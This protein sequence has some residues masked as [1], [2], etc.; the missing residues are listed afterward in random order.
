[1]GGLK[2]TVNVSLCGGIPRSELLSCSNQG[3]RPPSMSCSAQQPQTI[4][5]TT[6]QVIRAAASTLRQRNVTKLVLP[7]A[8][9]IEPPSWVVPAKG[10][11][12]LEPIGESRHL[13]SQVDL[14]EKACIRFGR[15]HN[16]DVQ[17]LH[18]TSS[19]KHAILF[20]HPN[21]SCYVVDCG[22]AHGTY[23][24]GKRVQTFM[25]EGTGTVQPYKVK[26]GALIRFGGPGAPT[27]ILKAFSIGFE[28]FVKNLELADNLTCKNGTDDIQHPN[29]LSNKENVPR[30]D[31]IS[32]L[33]F[34][35]LVKLNT[36]LNS[37]LTVS[38][39]VVALAASRLSQLR[40][41]ANEKSVPLRMKRSAEP[42]SLSIQ[43][44]LKKPRFDFREPIPLTE[45]K[46]ISIISPD[47]RR[48]CS[49]PPESQEMTNRP[50]VSPNPLEIDDISSETSL[51]LRNLL[52]LQ[53]PLGPEK[54]QVKFSEDP[55]ECFYPSPIT[56]DTSDS[57]EVDS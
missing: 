48:S 4:P 7:Q 45:L 56:P 49:P 27:Y 20:H 54:K 38:S 36:R 19:R 34:D 42:D 53:L 23:V 14:T 43:P 33:S 12:R 51:G 46:D 29:S 17:L 9:L 39:N 2:M 3:K 37:S 50:I 13:Q 15:S 44:V 52:A 28:A 57:E 40:E 22:S 25:E 11:S 21:G 24:N 30:R 1:M 5:T 8:H 47:R 16:S 26:R 18:C 32:E 41:N 6:D 31:S 55:P 10:E 35:S